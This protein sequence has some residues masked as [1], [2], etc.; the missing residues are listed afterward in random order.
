MDTHTGTH[1]TCHNCHYLP[2]LIS[3]VRLAPELKSVTAHFSADTV[4]PAAVWAFTLLSALTHL[5][6]I[7]RQRP[8]REWSYCTARSRDGHECKCKFENVDKS[9]SNPRFDTF[10]DDNYRG[11]LDAT[12][13]C[14]SHRR[15]V[16]KAKWKLATRSSSWSCRW[17]FVFTLISKRR[18]WQWEELKTKRQLTSGQI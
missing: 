16:Q 3:L 18:L 17:R 9:F 5:N 14:S 4:H 2:D 1:T 7:L 13:R 11:Y 8:W 12:R 15:S 6:V 10:I